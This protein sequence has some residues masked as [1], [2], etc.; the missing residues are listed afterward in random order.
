M[1]CVEWLGG[2]GFTKEFPVEKFYRDAKIGEWENSS[3]GSYP[4][5]VIPCRFTAENS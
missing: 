3:L 4:S 2:V 1:Q 5:E